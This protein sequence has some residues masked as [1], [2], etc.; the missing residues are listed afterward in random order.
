MKILLIDDNQEITDPL[1]KFLIVKG[2]D[3]T[4]LND[5]KNGLTL[6]EGNKFDVVILDLAMPKFSGYDVIDSLEKSGKLKEQK[7]IVFSAVSLGNDEIRELEKRG[8]YACIKKPIKLPPLL[9]MIEG[10]HDFVS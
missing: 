2:H 6:L 4:V 10:V 5:G 3:C 8:V 9:K 7:I 1:S